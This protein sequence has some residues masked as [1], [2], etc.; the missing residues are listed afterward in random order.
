MRNKKRKSWDEYFL[1]LLNSVA[2]R[3]TCNRGRN[4]AIITVDNEIVTAGYVGSPSGLP[5]CDEIGHLMHKVIDEEGNI[6]QHCIR[7]LHAEQNAILQAA[8]KGKA[9]KGGTLYCR[10]TPCYTCAKMIVQVGI[11]RIVA[12]KRYHADKLSMAFFKK[13]EIEVKIINPTVVKY[14]KQ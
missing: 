9:I 12:E 8:K 11:K 5:H 6:S 7:T 13:A 2:E 14:K 10:M 4:A 1:G 3:A